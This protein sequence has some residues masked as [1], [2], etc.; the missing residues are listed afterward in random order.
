MDVCFLSSFSKSRVRILP[1][2]SRHDVAQRVQLERAKPQI[3][4]ITAA[5]IPTP[6]PDGPAPSGSGQPDDSAKIVS[7]RALQAEPG[8]QPEP[9]DFWFP[10]EAAGR[11]DRASED[12]PVWRGQ[13]SKP[14]QNVA[15]V[16]H[17]AQRQRKQR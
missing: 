17:G 9:A 5:T 16:G 1:H 4:A 13:A 3:H 2:S 7:Q 11:D 12:Q 6:A 8:P 14:G 15:A 10:A